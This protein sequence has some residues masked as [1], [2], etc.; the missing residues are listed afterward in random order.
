MIYLTLIFDNI[1]NIILQTFS[2]NK[3]LINLLPLILMSLFIIVNNN[4]YNS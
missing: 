1:L 3:E 4:I 2:I